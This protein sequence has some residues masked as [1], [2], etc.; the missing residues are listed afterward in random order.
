MSSYIIS[1][2][3]GDQFWPIAC[4]V[5]EKTHDDVFE[6]YLRSILLASAFTEESAALNGGQ[7]R[8]RLDRG[9]K[10]L[11]LFGSGS[12]PHIPCFLRQIE[13]ITLKGFTCLEEGYFGIFS[14][15]SVIDLSHCLE[16]TEIPSRCFEKLQSLQEL[17][18]PGAVELI[19][20]SAFADTNV[21]TIFFWG[22]KS[23][24]KAVKIEREGN[25]SLKN[26]IVLCLLNEFE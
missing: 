14:K 12:L 10:E 19:K 3:W 11:L 23:Q 5:L 24:W 13:S 17:W 8:F 1:Q 16:V 22:T 7:A 9:G 21:S 4:S 26:A 18:L 20:A 6:Y 15:L 2:L 25:E